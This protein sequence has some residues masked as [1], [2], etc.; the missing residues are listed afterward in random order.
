[1]CLRGLDGLQLITNH[2]HS[3]LLFRLR[4]PMSRAT[5][6]PVTIA[7]LFAVAANVGAACQ[8]PLRARDSASD[9]EHHINVNGTDRVYFLHIPKSLPHGKAALVLVFH[10]GGGHAA[11]MPKFTQ[12]DPLADREGFFVAYPDSFNKSW[13]DSRGLSP[14]DDVGFV[15]LLI[16]QLQHSYKIDHKRIY[17][18]GISNGGF[19]S[20]RL[21]C[22][23]SQKIAAV[24]AVAAT[25]P[26]PLVPLCKPSEP[27]SA[28]FIHGTKDPLVH[29][30]GGPIGVRRDR[31]RAVSLHEAAEFWRN[32]DGTS[33]KSAAEEVSEPAHDSTQVRREVYVGGRDGTEVIV[34]TVEGGGH[35]WPGGSQYLPAFLIGK[36]SHKLDATQVIWDFFKKHRR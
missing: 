20:M 29:I 28:M 9:A 8:S 10:G 2:L 25:M 7:I 30:N 13:N 31:G 17:A 11:N 27:V 4:K 1:V 34:Y 26:E 23:L 15:R 19:F 14:A 22:D 12:F 6:R 35:T 5:K 21:A 3:H 36:V 32:R 18:T 33:S 16:E 24:A